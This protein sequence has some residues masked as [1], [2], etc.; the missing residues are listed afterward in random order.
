MITRQLSQLPSYKIAVAQIVGIQSFVKGSG[1]GNDQFTEPSHVFI[2]MLEQQ[3]Q[4]QQQQ[5]AR[6]PCHASIAT[7]GIIL[8]TTRKSDLYMRIFP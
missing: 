1:Q 8:L 6:S 4:Q 5:Q 7:S 2:E 3:Q